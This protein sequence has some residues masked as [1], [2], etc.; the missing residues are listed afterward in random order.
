MSD[1]IEVRTMRVEAG[2]KIYCEGEVHA[3][4][5]EESL[6]NIGCKTTVGCNGGGM[7]SVYI[8]NVPDNIK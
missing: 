2:S 4:K 8:N 5:V 1:L 3:F 7:W 6:K